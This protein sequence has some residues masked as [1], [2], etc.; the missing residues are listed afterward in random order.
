MRTLFLIG[1]IILMLVLGKIYLFPKENKVPV[2]GGAKSATGGGAV[3]VDVYVIQNEKIDNKIMASGTIMPNEEVDLK[4]EYAGRLVK[5]NIQEG[6]FVTKGQLI[7]KINDR[8]LKAQLT[9]IEYNQELARKIEGRQKKLLTIEA[10]NL[11][12]YDITSN[13]INVL[14]A[15]KEVVA[16][17]LEKTEIR[18][19]FSGRIGLKYISEGAYVSPSTSIVSIVQSNPVK[20]DFTIPDK[21]APLVK[22]G[23][24][25]Q[26]TLNGDASIHTAK[27]VAIDPKMDENLRT[28]K[29]RA[30]VA[31]PAGRFV[32]GM[33]V[34]I[35][36]SLG[37]SESAVM[38][39]TES[40]V[41]VLKGK[42]VYVVKNGKAEERM[43]TTGTRTDTKIQILEGLQLGDSLITS[44]IIAIKSNT[45]VKAK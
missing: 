34:K 18:A 26:F 10:I 43:V 12:E 42:K 19:P 8:E 41:P 13:N 36:A 15:E 3:S 44:G 39:P 38:I 7:G 33:F 45:K 28:L 5:L 23:T 4:A 17:Q 16:S 37:G 11:E 32:P 1:G 22:V 25:V 6:A 40:I 20:I 14:E 21:Y 30:M 27:V 29:V 2:N 24:S 31:N 35:D 9:K